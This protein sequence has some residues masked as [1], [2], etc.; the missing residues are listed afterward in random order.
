MIDLRDKAAYATWHYPGA[1]YLEFSRMPT[2]LC[3]LRSESALLLYCEFGLK[4]AHLA[5][6][7]RAAGLDAR[8]FSGGEKALRK[9]TSLRS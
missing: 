1:L 3:R 4:S 7:M 2:G 8:H 6:R 5:D 9:W